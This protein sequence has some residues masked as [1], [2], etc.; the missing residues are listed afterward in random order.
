MD[1][2]IPGVFTRRIDGA[3]NVAIYPGRRQHGPALAKAQAPCTDPGRSLV[4]LGHRAHPVDQRG[5]RA[6]VMGL[7]LLAGR[8]IRLHQPFERQ[9]AAIGGVILVQIAG[10]VGQLEG[11]AQVTGAVQRVLVIGGNAHDH[12]HHHAHGPGDMETVLQQVRFAARS[13]VSGIERETGDHVIGH[14]R[15]DAAFARD[16]AK[17]IKRWVARRRASQGL[18]GQLPDRRQARLGPGLFAQGSAMVLV[19][20]QV[21]AAAAP[22][23]E[24]P[25]PL[26]GRA[27]EQ[28]AGHGKA[29]RSAHDRLA[30]MGEEPGA[31]H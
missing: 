28:A 3:G 1:A 16:Q 29:F 27:I 13:P 21:I 9:I 20:G 6:A 17:G 15:G 19:I 7:H 8:N 18:G 5:Q 4:S 26:A 31:V 12:G 2:V 14:G 10:D 11:E 25:D 30:G 23:I 24:Q 22:G